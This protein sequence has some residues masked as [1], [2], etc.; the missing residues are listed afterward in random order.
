MKLWVKLLPVFIFF[1]LIFLPSKIEARSGCC[2]RHGGVCGCGCCDG[3]GLSSTCAPY[4]PECNGGGIRTQPTCPS[5]SIYNS[6]TGQCECLSGYV[7]SGNSCISKNQACTN[8]YGY[9]TQYD[10]STDSCK[11]LSGYV[12]NS[13]GTACISGN[14]ACWN[15][16]GFGSTYDYLSE[17]CKCSYGYVFNKARTKCITNDEACRELNGIMS[18]YSLLTDKCVCLS[19][20]EF[21]GSKCS[22]SVKNEEIFYPPTLIP[23]KKPTPTLK[24]TLTI[25]PTLTIEPSPTEIILPTEILSSTPTQPIIQNSANNPETKTV[26]PQNIF[27]RFFSWLFGKR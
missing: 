14:Q 23:T 21:D 5:M 22:L 27:F 24:P 12:W 16:F 25:T 19:G 8:K 6:L 7:A 11:C 15:T 2:S 13:S 17:K 4:Y 20:Y 1:F 18:E 3:T 9:M 10:Y 26:E